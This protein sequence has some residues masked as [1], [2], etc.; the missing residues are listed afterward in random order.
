MMPGFQKGAVL[1]V[2]LLVL[3]LGSLYFLL[4]SANDRQRFRDTA[5][6]MRHLQRIR[7]ALVGHAL[8]TGCLPCPATSA[9]SG[10][11]P[12]SCATAASRF[13]FVPWQTLG[14]PATDPW[15]GLVRYRVTGRYAT[16]DCSFTAS[17]TGDAIVMTRDAGGN[18]QTIDATAPFVLLSHGPGREGAVL[19]SGAALPP[20]DAGRPDERTN[21]LDRDR[22]VTRPWTEDAGAPGGPFD[23]AILWNGSAELCRLLATR[24][25]WSCP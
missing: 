18:L 25:G 16:G 17:S 7:D 23:D 9:T 20:P 2:A 3:V 4:V 13:G 15:G 21:L 10:T 11:A 24:K 12:G 8:E 5:P 19:V 6:A 1:L 14:V 22:F